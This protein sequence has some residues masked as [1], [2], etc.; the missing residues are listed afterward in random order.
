MSSEPKAL[1]SLGEICEAFK[2]SERT[3]KAWAKAGAPIR[4]WGSGN[5]RRYMT[6]EKRL[7]DWVLFHDK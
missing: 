1:T 5:R 6:E 2:Q 4:V 7:W 3:I